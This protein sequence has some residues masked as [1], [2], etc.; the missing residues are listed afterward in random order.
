VTTETG[1]KP[2]SGGVQL[3][4]TLD[5]LR[6][7]TPD[8]LQQM[9]EV[10]DAHARSLHLTDTGELRALEPDEKKAL[11]HLLELR[12]GII[13]RLDEHKRLQEIFRRRPERVQQV[14]ANLR[15]GLPDGTDDVRR[16][17]NTEARDKAL[18]SLD[19]R[20]ATGHL[21][22]DQKVQVERLF[23][24]DHVI[25][26]RA[27]VTETEAYRTAWQKAVTDPS[28]FYTDEER[29]AMLRWME[30][31]AMSENTTTAG[32]FGIP[33]FID[34]SII[35]TAQGSANPFLTIARQVT[36]N[37]NM[38]KGVSSAGV[39][40]AFQTES[41]TAT[42]NSPT[43]AQP[44]VTVHMARGT[45]P[46]SIEVGMDYPQFASEM[47]M[48]LAE[49]YDE[50]LVDKLTRGSGTT[51]PKGILTAISA[52]AGDRVTVTTGGSLGAP[53]PYKVWAALPQRYRRKAQWLMSV[54]VNNAI[55]Q[56][57]TANN[58]HA[59]TD[60]LPAEW[61][62]VLFKSPVYESPYMP[63]TTT[64][65]TT[66]SVA[67]IVGDFQNFVVARNGGMTVELVPHLVQQVTAGSGPALPT[68]QRAWFAWARIGSDASNVSGFRALVYNS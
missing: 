27:L 20:E 11:D 1:A 46:Y 35:L 42:D 39:S 17:T 54:G 22:D 21:A 64:W 38:W 3:P 45:I 5:D 16:M 62:D 50:L 23:R 14:Y 36:V 10:V 8:E 43:L 52:T 33:V 6:G 56:L 60:N 7:L 4:N 28:P 65:T 53:D 2:D 12:E 51:E 44:S 34:P 24:S 41:A 31:R 18:R 25:A 30:F 57:G 48:L 67:A 26:R 61:L 59:Y 55:R 32:G 58:Y 9:F 63:D 47:S 13:G 49:G 29:D 68:G 37:T 15:N 19:S 40:W 66:G